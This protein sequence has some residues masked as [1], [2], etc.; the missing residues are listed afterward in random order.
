MSCSKKEK[1]PNPR[2]T[3]DRLETAARPIGEKRAPTKRD[4]YL[5]LALP[6][7]CPSSRKQANNDVC[8]D[9]Y[10]NQKKVRRRHR[11]AFFGHHI[12]CRFAA[13]SKHTY[14]HQMQMVANHFQIFCHSYW[15]A[16]TA[17]VLLNCFKRAVN[18][19]TGVATV[20]SSLSVSLCLSLFFCRRSS[21]WSSC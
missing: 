5:R 10:R 7:L 4:K 13:R 15:L 17:V 19:H 6:K 16:D 11:M 21:G 8:V 18:V 9:E 12:R 14:V 20:S 1:E 2:L 3:G